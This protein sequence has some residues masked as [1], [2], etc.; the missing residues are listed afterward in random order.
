MCSPA[1]LAAFIQFS[2]RTITFSP[3]RRLVYEVSG[4]VSRCSPQ[5]QGSQSI[6]LRGLQQILGKLKCGLAEM[7]PEGFTG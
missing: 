2:P 5:E 1:F 6:T 4:H 3:D 7:L